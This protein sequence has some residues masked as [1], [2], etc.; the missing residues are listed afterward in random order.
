[1]VRGGNN[2]VA[3]GQ[4]NTVSDTT[5]SGAIRGIY[6]GGTSTLR[7]VDVTECG[8]GVKSV[9]T[10]VLIASRLGANTVAIDGAYT[11]GGGNVLQ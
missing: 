9:A 7:N 1:M 6:V 3:G 11:N 4:F 5:I 8:V 10:V 2:G